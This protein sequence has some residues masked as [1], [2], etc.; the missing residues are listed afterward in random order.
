MPDTAWG[1]PVH[2]LI[3]HLVVFLVPLTVLAALLVALWSKARRAFAPW[4]LG[5]A[6]IALIS[7][8]VATQSGEHLEEQ[9]PRSSLVEEHAELGDT[10]LPLVAALWV[11][12]AVIVAVGLYLRRK[13]DRPPNWTKAVTL[14]AVV[15]AIGAAVVSGVQVVRIGHSGAKA[16]WSDVGKGQRG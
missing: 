12:L 7:I 5:L 2:P 16:V 6:T 8:P 15:V 10:L 14:V 3:V 9:V 11:A 4:V 1:L 13:T